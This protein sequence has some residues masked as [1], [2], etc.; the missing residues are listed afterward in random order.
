MLGV[1]TSEGYDSY[2]V[3]LF[4]YLFL[5]WSSIVSVVTFTII[6]VAQ[7]NRKSRWRMTVSIVRQQTDSNSR[8]QR[9][10]VKMVVRIAT[11]LIVFNTPAATVSMAGLIEE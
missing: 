4:V 5:G 3:C 8:R 6:L 11:L 10:V 7:F 9:K 2:G 1:V